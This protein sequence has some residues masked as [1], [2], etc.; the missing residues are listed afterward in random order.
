MVSY[1]KNS[2][3]AQDQIGILRGAMDADTIDLG[4]QIQQFAPKA[5][6]LLEEIIEGR[7]EGRDASIRQRGLHAEKYLDRAGYSPVKKVA[8]VST[9]LTRQDIEAIKNRARQ[10]ALDAGVAIIEAEVISDKD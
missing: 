5:L 4:R 8:T 1:T 2:K 9:T 10:S 7:G 6:Q 3:A